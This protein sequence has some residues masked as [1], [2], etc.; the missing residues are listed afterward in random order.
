MLTYIF[1]A[2]RI[3]ITPELLFNKRVC[4]IFC[5][6]PRALRRL[7]VVEMTRQIKETM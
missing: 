5:A 7:E 6:T 2:P 4:Y 1:L 3:T